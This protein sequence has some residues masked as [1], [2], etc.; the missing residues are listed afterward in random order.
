MMR[1]GMMC[2]LAF[3]P[4]APVDAHDG[5]VSTPVEALSQGNMAPA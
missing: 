5:Q 2:M 3:A 1:V 4:S